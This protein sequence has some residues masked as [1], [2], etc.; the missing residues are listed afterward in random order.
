MHW[1]SPLCATNC[2]ELILL[3][4]QC[5][6]RIRSA[7]IA[8]SPVDSRCATF[9]C[10]TLHGILLGEYWHLSSPARFTG[11]VRGTHLGCSLDQDR[12]KPRENPAADKS[13]SPLPWQSELLLS[14]FGWQRSEKCKD[15]LLVETMAQSF[16]QPGHKSFLLHSVVVFAPG[17]LGTQHRFETA[18]RINKFVST[19]AQQIKCRLRIHSCDC[20]CAVKHSSRSLRLDHPTRQCCSTIQPSHKLIC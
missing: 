3:R 5:F 19:E 16:C 6:N 4:L 2:M 18:P 10:T 15:T 17:Y 8:F 1:G 11:V 20:L 9:I 7:W 13:H 14:A 12:V